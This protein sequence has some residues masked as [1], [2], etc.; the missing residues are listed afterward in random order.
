[1]LGGLATLATLATFALFVA[2]YAFNYKRRIRD[3]SWD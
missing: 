1:M 3:S 2:R